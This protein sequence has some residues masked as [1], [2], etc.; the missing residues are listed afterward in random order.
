[1]EMHFWYTF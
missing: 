1:M